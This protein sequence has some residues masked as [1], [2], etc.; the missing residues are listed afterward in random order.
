MSQVNNKDYS[1]SHKRNQEKTKPYRPAAKHRFE[2]GEE[3]PATDYESE[4]REGEAQRRTQ[5]TQDEFKE[6]QEEIVR[7]R[8]YEFSEKLFLIGVGCIIFSSVYFWF[9]GLDVVPI[10]V[11]VIGVSLV[12]FFLEGSYLR[13]EGLKGES[14]YA[15]ITP[16]RTIACSR[17]PGSLL[18]LLA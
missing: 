14:K 5:E 15:S 3:G 6:L 1:G 17:T 13:R 12:A 16:R 9:E 18:L 10:I 8:V 4:R 7:K 11:T 2:A